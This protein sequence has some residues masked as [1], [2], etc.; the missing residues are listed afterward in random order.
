M[1]TKT[2]SLKNVPIKTN[3]YSEKIYPIV[4]FSQ[5]GKEHSTVAL[6]LNT[7]QAISLATNLLI[8]AKKWDNIFLTAFRDTN[9]VTITSQQEVDEN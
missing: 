8:G 3:S 2:V 5:N 7:E 4:S 6:K 9:S 1:T